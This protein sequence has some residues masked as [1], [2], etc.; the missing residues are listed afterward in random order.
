MTTT[1]GSTGK[2]S[3][4]AAAKLQRVAAIDT[5]TKLSLIDLRIEWPI[6]LSQSRL[7]DLS[8]LRGTRHQDMQKGSMEARKKRYTLAWRPGKPCPR[9]PV[10]LRLIYWRLPAAEYNSMCSC[11]CVYYSASCAHR[12]RVLTLRR[13][14]RTRAGRPAR[15]ATLPLALIS[16][17]LA[18]QRGPQA[19][20]Q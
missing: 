5:R 3:L 4:Q 11:A 8:Q 2:L 9:T 12:A 16:R 6:R 20:H 15:L 13:E 14:R 19:A 1:A 10:D 7:G 18:D 17:W